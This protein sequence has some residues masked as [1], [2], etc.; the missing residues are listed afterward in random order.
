MGCNGREGAGGD[1]FGTDG[2]VDET[3][4]LSAFGVPA[5]ACDVDARGV[6]G[7]LSSASSRYLDV[8][9]F[10][11]KVWLEEAVGR[12]G[13]GGLRGGGR[14]RLPIEARRPWAGR[15]ESSS[16]E[17]RSRWRCLEIWVPEARG[18]EEEEV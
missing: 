4:G 2:A 12:D 3:F 10:G 9:G 8:E 6:A 14:A 1:F 16:L 18:L 11:W 7:C 17:E 15:M 5:A 13:R